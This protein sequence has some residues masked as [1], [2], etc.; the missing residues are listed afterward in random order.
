MFVR[1]F[2]C[3]YING[4]CVNVCTFVYFSVVTKN[5]RCTSL[6]HPTGPA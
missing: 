1:L 5:S 3:L 4:E 2:V 6:L